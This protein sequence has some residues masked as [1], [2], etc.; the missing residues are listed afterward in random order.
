M[1]SQINFSAVILGVLLVVFVSAYVGI[2]SARSRLPSDRPWRRLWLV[3]L[4]LALGCQ[5]QDLSQPYVVV[6]SDGRVW[7]LDGEPMSRPLFD[8]G[9]WLFKNRAGYKCRVRKH[10]VVVKPSKDFWLDEGQQY[11]YDHVWE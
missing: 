2:S 4:T 1:L 11:V 6:H 7:K 8:E 5:G 3:V 9:V 10:N